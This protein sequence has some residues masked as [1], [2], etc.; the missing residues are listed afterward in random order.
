MIIFY[1]GTDH[2]RLR[3]AVNRA[4]ERYHAKYPGGMSFYNIDFGETRPEQLEEA[5]KLVSLFEELKLVRVRNSFGPH[6]DAIA[7]VLKAHNVQERSDLVLLVEEL[8]T[9]A[10][11][12]KAH[13]E[14]AA[15][16]KKAKTQESFTPLEGPALHAWIKAECK[17]RGAEIKP[18]ALSL[19][20]TRVG[21]D[22]TTLIQEVEKLCNYAQGSIA[23][24][25]VQALVPEDTTPRA[26]ALSDAIAGRNRPVAFMLFQQELEAGQEPHRLLALLASQV[27]NLL[28]AKDL[29]GRSLNAAQIAVKAKLHPFVARK[30]VQSA[31]LFT[32]EELKNMHLQLEEI[33]HQAKSGQAELSSLLSRFLLRL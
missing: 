27:R 16:F 29:A 6:A 32:M 33:E 10:E 23:L 14:L 13:K 30:I 7:S 28:T 1:H 22:S 31:Q 19:L 2:Y 9:E 3:M 17:E 4:I 11:S 20:I 26:F 15:L 12:K 8:R 18:D 24:H 5:C 21:N 25:A